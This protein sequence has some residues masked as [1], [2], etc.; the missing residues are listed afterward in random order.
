MNLRKLL[1]GLAL[2]GTLIT[3]AVNTPWKSIDLASEKDWQIQIDGKGKWQSVKVPYGGWNSDRQDI[4]LDENTDVKDFV[5][6]RRWV[7]IPKEAKGKVVKIHFGAVNFGAEIYLDGKLITT[8]MSNFT[9]FDADITSAVKPGKRQLLEVKTYLLN[10]FKDEKGSYMMP[11][12]FIYDR[13]IVKY[14]FGIARKVEMNLYPE[15]YISDLFIKP[16]VSLTKLSYEIWIENRTNIDRKLELSAAL[17][18]WNHDNFR[19]PTINDT[20]FIAKANSTTHLVVDHIP[21]LLGKESY[22]W[23]NIPFREGYIA[24]LHHLALKVR[25]GEAEWN[26]HTQRFGF[27]EHNEG[28]YYYTINGVRVNL[29]SDATAVTQGCVYDG[30]TESEAFKYISPDRGCHETWKRY[31]RLGIRANRT[32]QEPP[33]QNILDAADEVGFLIIPE[34]AIR[35]SHYP[36]SND[37]ENPFYREHIRGM[38][39]ECRNHPSTAR[40]SL[41]NELH[42]VPAYLDMALPYDNT[43]PYVFETNTHGETTRVVSNLG[44]A[45]VMCHYVDYP[46]PAH[47]IYGLGEYAWATDGIN[48]FAS[49]GKMMRLNDICYFSGW[50]WTNYW[51][52]FLEGWS[53]ETYAWQQNNHPDRRNSIDGWGSPL[54]NY[55]IKSLH[56]YLI[57]DKEIE[58][59]NRFTADWPSVVP[60]LKPGEKSIRE[61]E[62]FNDGLFGENI[63]LSWSL[64][65]DNPTGEKVQSNTKDLIIKPGFH[66]TERL[67]LHIPRLPEGVK[68]RKLYLTLTSEKDGRV[69]FAENQLW[70]NVT[71]GY[72]INDIQFIGEDIETKGTWQ[73]KYGLEGYDIA[74]AN[75]KL[76]GYISLSFDPDVNFQVH[77]WESKTDDVRGLQHFVNDGKTGISR[78]A[79]AYSRYGQIAMT[80]DVGNQYRQIAIYFMDWNN[81]YKLPIHVPEFNKHFSVENFKQGKYLLFKVRGKVTIIVGDGRNSNIGGIFIDKLD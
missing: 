30:Y 62:I 19:Y 73:G 54:I 70:Y 79:A 56:P 20:A 61:L 72:S 66:I 13:K 43:R 40:Y 67:E 80:I 78:I 14:P 45:Y 57:M 25:E 75:R 2:L 76:P 51:P 9:A 27:V 42:A 36:Q 24:K 41:S 11:T 44:H 65:W 37:P 4:L 32:H 48:E 81:D 69:L 21:W 5:I 58:R 29:P 52:N 22:W 50:S 6:Y 71:D 59:M 23:P 53:H 68:E 8:Y 47:G 26:S 10:H 31:M 55:V 35:G 1:T 64:R 39:Q 28:P 17:S 77:T 34:T 46:L 74:G 7:D 38:V 63:R 49:Q 18:S 12:G 33:T 60:F 3:E 16:S 15:V